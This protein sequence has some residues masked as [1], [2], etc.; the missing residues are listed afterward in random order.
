MDSKLIDRFL[1]GDA[2]AFDALVERHRQRIFNLVYRMTNDHDWA[3]DM[4]VDVFVEVFLSL[5]KFKKTARFSTWLHRVA[6]NVCLESIRRR[7]SKKHLREVP[8]GEAEPAVVSDLAD[9]MTSNGLASR[10][11]A[12][13]QVLPDT[14][15]AA[16]TMFYIEEL[17]CAEIANILG[18]PRN[19]AKTRIF[20]ATKLLRD[21]LRADGILPVSNGRSQ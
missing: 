12:A 4:T 7:K 11:T 5:P 19:T 2:S 3:E 15:R 13:M 8:L 9:S 10:V 6:L 20:Y 21:K 18:I 14:H 16:M 17:S 1:E